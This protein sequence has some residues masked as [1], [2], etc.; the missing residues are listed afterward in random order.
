MAVEEGDTMWEI[1]PPEE[2]GLLLLSDVMNVVGVAIFRFTVATIS[3]IAA[4]P[5]H[6]GFHDST[7]G[8]SPRRTPE[9][10]LWIGGL[11]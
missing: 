1:V 7:S 11:R 10:I 8:T 2:T 6:H 9:V 3:I 4:R 5:H